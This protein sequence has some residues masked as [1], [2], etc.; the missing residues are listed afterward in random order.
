[1]IFCP[2][3]RKEFPKKAGLAQHNKN[4]NK[5]KPPVPEIIEILLE[6]TPKHKSE[7]ATTEF[8]D[9]SVLFNTTLTKEERQTSGIFFTPKKVRDILFD[10]ISGLSLHPSNILEP[11]FGS[12][13]FLFDLRDRYPSSNIVGVEINKELYDSVSSDDRL[14]LVHADFLEFESDV[15]FDII[16]GNPPYFVQE[17]TQTQT[18]NQQMMLGRPNIY[19]K[20]MYK[21]LS[22]HLAPNGYLAFIIPTSIYNCAY[23]QPMRDYI[24]KNTRICHVE[25]LEKPG[26]HDTCQETTLLIV[27]NIQIPLVQQKFVFQSVNGNLY[28][29]P[30][31]E[32]LKAISA[33]STT[34]NA[35][36]L[37]VKTGNVVWNQV[38]DHLVEQTKKDKDTGKLL[39]YS[40]NIKNSKL[41]L[42]N[43]TG[44]KK[45]YVNGLIKPTLT[46]DGVILVDRGYGNSVNFNFIMIRKE[47]QTD[48]Y[49]ENHLN[50]I[51]GPISKLERVF[52]SLKDSRT[53]RFVMIFNGNGTLSATDLKSIVPIF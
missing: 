32:E 24:V 7:Q 5:C 18:T 19:I 6:P 35:L 51:Y 3:C 37:S 28:I 45:Q 53:I 25:T 44:E 13:E 10:K 41:V 4:K 29:S 34:I 39:I 16:V 11:S 8:R 31:F 36:G 40:G 27:Q 30:H 50:V 38:K 43:L 15:Q 12:G 42:N 23:Y 2:I 9:S 48:F 1:M 22:K 14:Q 26:F 49:V 52:Q 46:D 20:I 33:G 47:E 21:C 17:K